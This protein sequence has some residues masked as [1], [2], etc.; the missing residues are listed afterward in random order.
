[1]ARIGCNVDFTTKPG[2]YG[3]PTDVCRVTCSRCGNS[4][5]S[6]GSSEKSVRRCMLML[7][8]SCP[9]GEKNYYTESFHEQKR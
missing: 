1:M 7:S 5:E 2:N 3:R 9:R 4:T 6:F 8:K